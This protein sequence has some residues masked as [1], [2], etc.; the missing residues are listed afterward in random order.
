[1]QI[2]THGVISFG[3]LFT[4]HVP[5]QFPNGRKVVAS[6]WDDIDLTE[7]GFFLYAA[8]TQ[9]QNSRLSNS[10][11]IF[12]TVNGYITDTVLKGASVFQA[13]WILAVRWIDTCPFNNPS[14]NSVCIY[15]MQS[16]NNFFLKCR[17]IHFKQCWQLMVSDPMPS[18]RMSVGN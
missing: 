3:T 15:V 16:M 18:I 1:M 4:E 12:D 6:Y 2:S 8:L 7:K 13:K 9:G 14:C 5:T 11:A 10:L 17:P